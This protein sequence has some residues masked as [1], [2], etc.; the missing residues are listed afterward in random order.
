MCI[1]DRCSFESSLKGRHSVSSMALMDLFIDVKD[2]AAAEKYIAR[3]KADAKP[4]MDERLISIH[5][6]SFKRVRLALLLSD[7]DNLTMSYNNDF[8]LSAIDNL[9]ETTRTFIETNF[10]IINLKEINI[11]KEQTPES[12]KSHLLFLATINSTSIHS[13]IMFRLMMLRTAAALFLYFE[14][15]MAKNKS[16]SL[17]PYYYKYFTKTCTYA[18]ALITDFNKF[19]KGEYDDCLSPLT[20]YNIC[21]LYTSRCV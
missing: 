17:L 10:P 12:L 21:L 18:L 4:T 11:S 9:A 14:S 8:P 19:F 6:Y 13:R 16:S 5:E 7:L 2:P 15:E 20:T 1:R 3:V